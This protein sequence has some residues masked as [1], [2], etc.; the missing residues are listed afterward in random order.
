M[1]YNRPPLHPPTNL[2]PRLLCCYVWH[3]TVRQVSLADAEKRA[4][5]LS[6]QVKMLADLAGSPGEEKAALG[7]SVGDARGWRDVR[8]VRRGGAKKQ[9]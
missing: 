3:C 8:S 5:E 1:A 6:W 9:C 4:K 7:S 2:L